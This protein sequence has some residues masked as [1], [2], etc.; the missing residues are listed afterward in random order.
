MS[1]EYKTKPF[2]HQHELFVKTRELASWGVFWEQGCG[3]TK[4]MIDT[5][6]FQWEEG[7]IDAVLVVAPA[8]VEKNW[9]TDEIPRHLP[10][11]VAEK[12]KFMH[13]RGKSKS[14][15]YHKK[16]FDQLVK[17]KD[18]LVW[19]FISYDTFMTKIGKNSVWRFL[20]RRRVLYLLDE[21]DDIR[22]PAAK[23]ARS[24]VASSIYA[25]YRRILTGTPVDKPFDYYTQ[26]RFLDSNIWKRR[27]MENFAAFKVYFA[28][29]LTREEAK[30]ELGYDPGYD[31]LIDYKNIEELTEIASSISDRLLKEDVLD[32][33]PKLYTKIWFEMTPRQQSFYDEL[34]D[35]LELELEDGRIID[36]N[37]AIVRLLRLQQ[38]TCGYLVVNG[39]E[40]IEMCDKRNPRL[41]ASI[42]FL[43][44]LNHPVIVWARFRNDIDQLM[45]ALGPRAVRYDGRL[46]ADACEL[47]KNKFNG[48]EAAF[49]VANPAKAA[50]GLTLNV[51]KTN[52]YYSNTFK[53]RERLQSE[54]RAHR[55]GQEGWEHGK[56]GFGVLNADCLASGT[57]DMKIVSNLRGKF[58]IA[59]KLNGD[60]LREWI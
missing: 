32:L 29:W 3:K 51:A 23:R 47:S 20:K 8:G 5:A 42:A 14:T 57:V 41:D 12:S 16:E 1:Y 43:E 2:D 6:A 35:E 37:L 11:R 55:I 40:P 22:T 26:L 25:P 4:P 15:K 28:E 46:D 60:V 19:L 54:D 34:R 24:I 38:I 10:D 18:H 27:D 30:V 31:K 44:R 49:F 21:S 59:A 52:Y 17:D 13:F 39:D 7:N 9:F 53:L 36:G 50:R 56:Y 58:N 45:D 33:P 48:G